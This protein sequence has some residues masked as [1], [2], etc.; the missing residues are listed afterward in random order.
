M[1]SY[2]CVGLFQFFYYIPHVPHILRYII[3]M[4]S[5]TPLT[6]TPKE[7]QAAKNDEHSG[8]DLNEPIYRTIS[9]SRQHINSQIRNMG[10]NPNNYKDLNG[11]EAMDAARAVSKK[12]AKAFMKERQ[13]KPWVDL[14]LPSYSSPSKP[15]V[16]TA[17]SALSI[18]P[19]PAHNSKSVATNVPD[20]LYVTYQNKTYPVHVE[21][22]TSQL[23]KKNGGTRKHNSNK[24]KTRKHLH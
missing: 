10:L 22:S 7:G 23:Q 8:V 16:P 2:I 21:S 3:E 20:M 17:S 14:G 12:A 24:R 11:E 5:N 15:V 9:L 1:T 13:E 18:T 4:F 6:L 19:A